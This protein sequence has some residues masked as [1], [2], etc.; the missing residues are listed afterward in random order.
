MKRFWADARAVATPGGQ[1]IHLD[2]RP[3][4]TPK[5]A[6]LL[7]P[8]APLAEAIA[9]EWQAAPDEFAPASLPLTGLANAAID[10]VAAD[11]PALAATLAAYAAADL[12]CYRAQG[13][14]PL[15][16]RQVAAWEPPLKA[17]EAAHGLVF[18]RTAGVTPVAQPPETLA[19]VSALLASMTPLEL[20]GLSP[21]VTLSGSLVLPLALHLGALDAEAAFAASHVDELWQAEHWGEDEEAAAARQARAA[22]FQAAARFLALVR[23]KAMP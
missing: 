18:R 6:P 14:Q 11:P 2:G 21:L 20:G 13:P 10:I 3:L 4:R 17:V 5:G 19:R 23:A 16:A 9:A 8:A 12:T 22:S 7:L 15:V 1:A